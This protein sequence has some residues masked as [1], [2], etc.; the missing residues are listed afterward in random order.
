MTTAI[1]KTAFQS[2]QQTITDLNTRLQELIVDEMRGRRI[3]LR[4]RRAL[5]R[6]RDKAHKALRSVIGKA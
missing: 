5:Q 1:N 2:A 4:T 6:E 3:P